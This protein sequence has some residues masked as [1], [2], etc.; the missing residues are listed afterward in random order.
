MKLVR[1]AFVAAAVLLHVACKDTASE[2]K[3]VSVSARP[4]PSAIVSP[5]PAVM[6]AAMPT[7]SATAPPLP[8]PVATRPPASPAASPKAQ[9]S[10]IPG[11]ADTASSRAVYLQH[12]AACHGRGGEGAPNGAPALKGVAMT[13][14][15]AVKV[16]AGGG[17]GMPAFKG[18]LTQKQIADL[19]R[20][21]RQE[22]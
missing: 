6:P 22:L 11:A 17:D 1:C 7:A 10:A 21:I 18:K 16:I 8:S 14:Q 20:F 5:S 19:A 4:S 15:K 2:N 9:A 12:C 13:E 3:T